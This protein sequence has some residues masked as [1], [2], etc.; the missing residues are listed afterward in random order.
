M[1]LSPGPYEEFIRVNCRFKDSEIQ[2][3]AVQEREGNLMEVILALAGKCNETS[4]APKSDS[5]SQARP[6]VWREN[7]AIKSQ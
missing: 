6:L 2:R 4:P 5:L 3:F 7:S 1:S